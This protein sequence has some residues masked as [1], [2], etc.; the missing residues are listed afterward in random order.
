MPEPTPSRVRLRRH[1]TTESI[2]R[3]FIHT[4]AEHGYALVG[5]GLGYYYFRKVVDWKDTHA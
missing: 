3:W 1:G 2:R 5:I 4:L